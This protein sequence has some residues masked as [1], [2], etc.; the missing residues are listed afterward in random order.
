MIIVSNKF[1]GNADS[2]N[3][4]TKILEVLRE[5]VYLDLMNHMN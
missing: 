3:P 5:D 4:G 1:P 2:V